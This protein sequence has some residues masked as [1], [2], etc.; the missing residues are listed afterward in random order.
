MKLY[1]VIGS[2]GEYSDHSEWPVCWRSTIEEAQLVVEQCQREAEAFQRWHN[3]EMVPDWSE[4]QRRKAAML[5]QS[6]THGYTGTRYYVWTIPEDPREGMT[7]KP[8]VAPSDECPFGDR[9]PC[10]GCS[11]DCNCNC[12]SNFCGCPCHAIEELPL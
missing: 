6:F 7:Q 2:S 5:D 4:E 8:T 10:K 9:E 1:V 3:A 12:G 11:D